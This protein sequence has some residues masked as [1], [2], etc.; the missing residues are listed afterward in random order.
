MRTRI[1]R[2]IALTVASAAA[3]LGLVG[4]GGSSTADPITCPPG[5]AATLNPSQ[6]GWVCV[7]NGGNT[8]NSEDPK[9]PNA[10]KGDF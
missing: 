5:Q 2:L 3:V 8:N 1:F 6:G 4:V 7:N 9:N 10:D